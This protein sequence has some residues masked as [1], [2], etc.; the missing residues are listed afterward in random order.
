[1]IF[2]IGHTVS[3]G[4]NPRFQNIGVITAIRNGTGNVRFLTANGKLMQAH[5]SQI[6]SAPKS[7]KIKTPPKLKRKKTTP[8]KK[9]KSKKRK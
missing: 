3:G 4:I 8:T 6:V 5:V 9:I 7:P 1:M 2:N